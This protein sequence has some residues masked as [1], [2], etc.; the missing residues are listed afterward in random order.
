MRWE[1]EVAKQR[2]GVRLKGGSFW[3]R[4][5]WLPKYDTYMFGRTHQAGEQVKAVLE[6]DHYR[7]TALHGIGAHLEAIDANQ[8]YT[9][10]HYAHVGAELYDRVSVGLYHLDSWTKDKRKL[11][12]LED[13]EMVVTGADVRL[14][15][16]FLGQA[17]LAY[18]WVD[19]EKAT[20][21]GPAIEVMHSYGGRGLAENYLGTEK[22]ENGTGGLK[23]FA[24]QYDVSL[25]SILKTFARDALPALRGGDATASLFGLY[26]ITRS[27][28]ASPD[29][30]V[31][32]DGRHSFKWGAEV[33]Y[34]PVASAGLSVRYDRV[35]QDV[36]DNASA[37]RILS[38]RISVRR[39]F[40]FGEGQLY[41]QWS[42]YVYGDRVRLRPG[43]VALESMPDDNVVKLQGQVAF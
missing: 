9:L 18:S 36:D 21:L 13:A 15:G 33:A 40:D 1:G 3:D 22:S 32:R 20:Y 37:F 26:A 43:Q 4:F 19:A 11:K 12:E 31:N 27:P 5:G 38:P 28:Q 35:V 17:Y 7:I 41:L 39:R 8:G 2:W 10:L 16:G 14:R 42:R 6:G 34:F 29:P 25:A 24:F 30:A 23:N